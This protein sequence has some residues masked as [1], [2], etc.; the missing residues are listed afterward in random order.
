MLKKSHYSTEGSFNV[1]FFLIEE[2]QAN[3]IF[4]PK[5]FKTMYSNNEVEKVDKIIEGLGYTF[6]LKNYYYNSKGAFV[7]IA[8]NS[9]YYDDD[10][11]YIGEDFVSVS[12]I[13]T[14][15]FNPSELLDELIFIAKPIE[16]KVKCPVVS[17]LGQNTSGQFYLQTKSL[18]PVTLDIENS[19]HTDFSLPKTIELIKGKKSGLFIFKGIP[20]SGKS[21][22]LK[23]LC[24]E[25]EKKFLYISPSEIHL[26]LD[27]RFNTFAFA[28]LQNAVIVIE[29]AEKVLEDRALGGS[30]FTSLILNLTSGVFGDILNC[31]IICTLNTA[32]NIDVALLRKGR[33][34]ASVNFENLPIEKANK[35]KEALG[36]N[37]EITAP[38][39]LTDIY[40]WEDNQ[41][42]KQKTKIG[43]Q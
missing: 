25:T 40:N 2:F 35:V 20:G 4:R 39:A 22:L 9:G 37:L 17:F 36:V 8:L 21:F 18:P 15:K 1:D 42:I 24:Q 33:L 38:I 11:N 13:H 16:T 27:S 7:I 32:D 6:L 26:L 30:H 41:V 43:F 19:Y 12:L 5:P 34:L 3:A 29:D 14:E 10:D 23:Y 31:Q 28:N